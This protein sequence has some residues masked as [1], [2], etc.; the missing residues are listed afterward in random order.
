VEEEE[1]KD[2]AQCVGCNKF[3]GFDSTKL[4]LICHGITASKY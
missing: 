2:E 1:P 3:F 4:L